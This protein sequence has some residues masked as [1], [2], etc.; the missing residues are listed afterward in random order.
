M[1][2]FGAEVRSHRVQKLA[3][4][5]FPQENSV[6]V[7]GREQFAVMTVRSS[8]AVTRICA[9]NHKIRAGRLRSE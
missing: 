9:L 1:L 7:I 8:L 6:A 5:D 3:A 2:N 4:A